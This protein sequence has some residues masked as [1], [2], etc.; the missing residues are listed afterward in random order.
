MKTL[1]TTTA[2]G[3]IDAAA[4]LNALLAHL[5]EHEFEVRPQDA[6]WLLD[7]DGAHIF[8]LA[9]GDSL[10]AEIMAPTQ[11]LLFDARMMVH[12]HLAEFAACD[13]TAIRWEGDQ[14][15]FE[16]PPAFRVLTVVSAQHLTPHMRRLRFRAEDL[17]RYA[18][19]ENLHCKL[20]L[21]QPGVTQPE[22]P[23]LGPDGLPCLPSGEKRLD[24]R[25]YTIR[26]IDPQAGWM[27]IDFVLHEDAGPGAAWAQRAQPGDQIGV[28][29][30]GGR[31]ARPA[32]WMLLAADETGLPAIA[33]IAESLPS[34]TRGEIMIEV[35]NAEDELPLS[36]PESMSLRW[37]HRNDQRPGQSSLLRHSIL[38]CDIPSEEDRFVWVA[39]EF[40]TAQTVRKWLRDTVGMSGKEQLVVAYWRLG[41][42]ETNM[43]SGGRTDKAEETVRDAGR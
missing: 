22:W 31:S 15:A 36:M 41:V 16:R 11:E 40:T 34:G 3:G 30:P 33:R 24:M 8:F 42:D 17:A 25:T 39:A 10:N 7:Y 35:Q 37:L 23:T 18:D 27:D 5:T 9:K 43:K 13:S 2:V 6:G 21:P 12:H 4:V 1:R 28:S 26:H 29:G 19:N 38:A 32:A 20:L 14:P